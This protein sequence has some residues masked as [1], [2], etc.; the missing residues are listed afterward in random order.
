M[1]EI[2]QKERNDHQKAV[3]VRDFNEIK[4]M[5]DP[6]TRNIALSMLMMDLE[7]MYH[8]PAMRDGDFERKNP[9]LMQFYREVA[10]TRSFKEGRN[11]RD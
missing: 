6:S 10:A 5:S 3:W 1:S 2:T 9:G 7:R 11:A 8:I 4:E